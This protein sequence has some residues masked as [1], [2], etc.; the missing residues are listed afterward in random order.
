[1][2]MA[3]SVQSR[4]KNDGVNNLN[5]ASDTRN[6]TTKNS[7][8]AEIQAKGYAWR[9]CLN[10]RRDCRAIINNPSTKRKRR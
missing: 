10:S 7:E 3:S 4:V 8:K 9:N 5:M 6:K 2:Q 1:M